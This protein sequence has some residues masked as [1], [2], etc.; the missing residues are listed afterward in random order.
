[1]PSQELLP[2]VTTAAC[3]PRVV[4]D[5]HAAIRSARRRVF[6]RDALQIAMVIAA[7]LLFLYWPEARL[8]FLDRATSLTFL[9]GVNVAIA[10]DLWLTRSWPR[11]TARRIASTWSRAERLRFSPERID[12]S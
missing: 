1:M 12:Q 4:C 3:P 6:F 8:P 7:N 2:G 11:W 5:A 10:M 9:A